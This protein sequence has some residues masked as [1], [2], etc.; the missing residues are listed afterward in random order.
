MSLRR[1]LWHVL[2]WAAVLDAAITVGGA[3]TLLSWH[4]AVATYVV[5][6][7]AIGFSFAACGA[8]IARLRPTNTVG[9]VLLAGGWGQLTS[10]AAIP[11]LAFGHAHGWPVPL[12]RAVLTA[13]LLCWPWGFGLEPLALLLFPTGQLVSRRWR[14]AVWIVVAVAVWFVIQQGFG[15]PARFP[16]PLDMPGVRT[17]LALPFSDLTYPLWASSSM[18]LAV[19]TLVAVWSL[20]VRYRHGDETL[21]RQILWIP[22][23]VLA[24]LV[25]NV[26]R[27]VLV[28]ATPPILPLLATTLT[29]MAIAIAILRHGLFDVRL[30]VSRAVVY[31]TL[32]V[33]VFAAYALLVAALDRLLR[34]SGAPVVATLVIALAFNPV[35]VRLQNLVDRALYGAR[36]D[37]VRAVSQVGERLAGDDLDGVL[38]GVREALHLPF[39]AL[40]HDGEQFA[41]S[42]HPPANLH[43]VALAYRGQPVGDLVVG[44]R[45][46]QR[47]LDTADQAVLNLLAT[48]LAVAL[49]ATTL[50]QELHASRQRLVAAREDERRRLHR[51]LHDSLGPT[52]TGA[53]LLADAAGNLAHTDPDTTQATTIE[54]ATQI[55]GAIDT[56]RRLVYGLRPS[57][58]DE[59]GL[60]EAL[61]RQAAQLPVAVQVEVPDSVPALPAAVEV[62]A[63]RI[64]AEALTNVVRHADA[65]RATVCL[66]I[67][68]ALRISVT[69]NGQCATVWQRGVG[70]DSIHERATELG[71]TCDVGPTPDGGRISA[72]LPLHLSTEAAS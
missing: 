39:A 18:L 65:T 5:T 67:D 60:V 6:N 41:T 46:G 22:L 7:G 2:V 36:G 48:P 12:L 50:S 59:L 16:L 27:I 38:R 64:V 15:E 62:A 14:P 34:G 49:H 10:A 29:P 25:V 40:Q 21:R 56:V 55:R 43:T 61:R 4:Q 68:G 9:W 24:M 47:R 42:G 53:A 33:A 52:L 20:V 54:A 72:V 17:Y 45:T 58:L 28:V 32:T 13:F 37:P 23:A 1:A 11:V 69:D 44:V 26:P 31:V 57:S 35:R 71:G 30:V 19:S 3:T 70:L 66:T 8:L 63:Y 51:E